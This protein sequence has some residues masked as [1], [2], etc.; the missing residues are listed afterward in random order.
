MITTKTLRLTPAQNIP[1]RSRQDCQRKWFKL[2]EIRYKKPEI[3][4][5]GEQRSLNN[6]RF[7]DFGFLSGLGRRSSDLITATLPPVQN[8]P[9]EASSAL[10]WLQKKSD[11][12]VEAPTRHAFNPRRQVRQKCRDRSGLIR[13]IRGG[14][15]FWFRRLLSP[16]L[17]TLVKLIRGIEWPFQC[18][19]CFHSICW[20]GQPATRIDPPRL[21]FIAQLVLSPYVSSKNSGFTPCAGPVAGSRSAGISGCAPVRVRAVTYRAFQK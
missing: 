18:L 7:S 16:V 6:V 10:P 3:R 19:C 11:L 12:F 2:R 13:M 8:F 4:K 1:S 15:G 17:A 14:G 21:W 9:R 20:A 5:A